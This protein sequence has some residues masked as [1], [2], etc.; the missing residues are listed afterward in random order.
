VSKDFIEFM[1]AVIAIGLGLWKVGGAIASF[2]KR[3][4]HLEENDEQ[5]GLVM[6]KQG[7]VMD[8]MLVRLGRI[9]GFLRGSGSSQ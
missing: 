8:A 6:T 5:Q 2:D 4:S 7:Q 9:E 3:L 1:A